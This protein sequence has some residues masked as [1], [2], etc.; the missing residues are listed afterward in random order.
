V[1][2][3]GAII[4]PSVMMGVERGNLD[5]LILALVGFAALGL[6][7]GQ[8]WPRIPSFCVAG[9]RRGLKAIPNVLRCARNSL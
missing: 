4:S 8:N 6:R 5:L 9:V 2:A 7:R 1:I 3:L